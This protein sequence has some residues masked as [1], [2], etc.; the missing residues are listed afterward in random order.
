MI[1]DPAIERGEFLAG[2]DPAARTLGEIG[3]NTE[4]AGSLTPLGG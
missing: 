2:T 1:V 3:G 4:A